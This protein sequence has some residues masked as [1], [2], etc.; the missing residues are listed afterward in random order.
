MRSLAINMEKN[1][2]WLTEKPVAH[3]GLHDNITIPENSLAAYKNAVDVFD[4][5]ISKKII[6]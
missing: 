5:K 1:T 3:R 2:S 6:L 4:P